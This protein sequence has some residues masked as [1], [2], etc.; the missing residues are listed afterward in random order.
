M[1]GVDVVRRLQGANWSAA[2]GRA[3]AA[4]FQEVIVD[5]AQ[6]C[7]PLDCQIIRWLRDSGVTVTIV[8]DFD[9]AI[10]GF[11][12]GSPTD[13]RTLPTATML[14]TACH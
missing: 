4:R 3:L 11:R 7:N 2:L 6:D 12:Q 8:A 10:Y 13:L 9:Q 1:S 5:E 14:K